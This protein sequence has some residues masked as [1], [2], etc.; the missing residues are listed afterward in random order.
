MDNGVE[1]VKHHAPEARVEDLSV[2]TSW[3]PFLEGETSGRQWFLFR[4]CYDG[5][6]W[7]AVGTVFY[8]QPA[9]V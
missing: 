1:S 5:G 2:E 9:S 3:A 7:W 6:L 8:P 4:E